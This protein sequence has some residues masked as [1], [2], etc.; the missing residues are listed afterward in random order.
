MLYYLGERKE[1]S[2]NFDGIVLITGAST[3][4][5]YHAA[6]HLAKKYQK[7][8][9]LAGVR[10]DADIEKLQELGISNLKGTPS[11]IL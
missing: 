6:L 7:I 11:K 8:L 9:V 5:G 3:G 2:V 10:K 1:F 4:I